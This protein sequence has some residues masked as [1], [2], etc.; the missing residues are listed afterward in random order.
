MPDPYPR[1]LHCDAAVDNQHR[2]RHERRVIRR[3]VREQ[4]SNLLR[5]GMPPQIVEMVARGIDMFDC[6]LPTRLARNG[7]AFTETGTLNMK[8]LL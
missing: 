4:C 7:T 3:Q 6:V 5:L 8:V 2:A 1:L